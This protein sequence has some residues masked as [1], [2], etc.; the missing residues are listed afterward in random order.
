MEWLKQQYSD[1]KGNLKY[2]LLRLLLIY[3]SYYV[4]RYL[5]HI[6]GFIVA[7][8]VFLVSLI[9]LV[10]LRPHTSPLVAK[11]A[12]NTESTV[13]PLEAKVHQLGREILE[14]LREKGPPP[15]PQFIYDEDMDFREFSDGRNAF[16]ILKR[17]DPKAAE[18]ASAANQKWVD[19]VSSGYAHRFANRV[20]DI[21]NEVAENGH[22][23]LG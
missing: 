7:I 10:V 11:V 17:N 9:V 15:F 1:I 16:E 5:P 14:F 4:V 18:Q 12:S 3:A 21:L 23:A 22:D 6:S 19:S 8:F 2:D 20:K 13:L